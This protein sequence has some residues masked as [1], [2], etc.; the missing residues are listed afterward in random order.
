MTTSEIDDLIT[1]LV[2]ISQEDGG[3]LLA[4]LREQV[5]KES[6]SN[7]NSAVLNQV[8]KTMGSLANMNKVGPVAQSA[9]QTQVMLVYCS[10]CLI[11]QYKVEMLCG[12][13]M[14]SNHPIHHFAFLMFPD[15]LSPRSAICRLTT[16]TRLT[17]MLLVTARRGMCTVPPA[18]TV[19]PHARPSRIFP[20]GRL[21]RWIVEALDA[22]SVV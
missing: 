7:G 12:S 21:P 19:L 20:P 11:F 9:G 1:L 16:T 17:D 5:A 18:V 14:S 4:S 22:I 6:N 2:V 13:K 10:L 3:D 15:L 8:I